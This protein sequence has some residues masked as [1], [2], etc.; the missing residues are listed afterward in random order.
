MSRQ[1]DFPT[2]ARICGLA[3]SENR[4]QMALYHANKRVAH[5]GG[6]DGR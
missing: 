1:F 6:R 5:D 3:R 4:L 2:G